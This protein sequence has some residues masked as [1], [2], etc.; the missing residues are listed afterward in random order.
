MSKGDI[1]VFQHGVDL[2][3]APRITYVQ[4]VYDKMAWYV[5]NNCQEVEPYIEYV[6]P[7]TL[8][9]LFLHNLIIT[10]TNC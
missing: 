6:F 7:S 9:L 5:L 3:G 1:S 4:N 2:L 10:A 8:L